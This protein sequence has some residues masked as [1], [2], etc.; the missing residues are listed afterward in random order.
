MMNSTLASV[1][2]IALVGCLP[3]TVP[4]GSSNTYLGPQ[5]SQATIRG[6]ASDSALEITH[7]YSA[8]GFTLIDQ[9]V[10]GPNGQIA[11]EYKGNRNA[12]SDRARYNAE[13]GSIASVFYVWVTPAGPDSSNVS[14]FG[15]PTIDN[16]QPCTDGP[17]LPCDKVELYPFLAPLMSGADEAEIVHGVFSELALENEIIGAVPPSPEEVHDA[18]VASCLDQRRKTVA[19]S[20]KLDHDA[21]IELLQ[22]LPASCGDEVV[23]SS[24]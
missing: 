21:R 7:L 9:H 16:Q 12:A 8:R 24:Q 14:M 15:K 19:A 23:S 20:L 18:S 5:G 10:T 1:L 4:I 17:S 6:T 3:S 2:A 22:K 13:S 11:L